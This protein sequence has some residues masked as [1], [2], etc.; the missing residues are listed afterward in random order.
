MTNFRST[1][2]EESGLASAILGTGLSFGVTSDYELNENGSLVLTYGKDLS[3]KTPDEI[4]NRMKIVME[5][6]APLEK[7]NNKFLEFLVVHMDINA[8]R[9]WWSQ[10]DTYRIGVTRLSESTMHTLMKGELTRAN[11]S[12]DT[13]QRAI[14]TVNSC[15]REGAFEAAKASLPEGFM[16]RR[17]VCTNAKAIRNM[18]TQRRNHRLKEWKIFWEN[19][20]CDVEKYYTFSYALKG[21]FY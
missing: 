21:L 16:Q 10:F 8:P 20:E 9:Y 14:D 15:I 2:L 1:V 17:I 3:K 6:L 5:K 7:G 19:V 18:Y 12:E 13:P 11:F 4:A